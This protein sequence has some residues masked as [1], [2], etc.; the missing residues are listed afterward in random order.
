[1]PFPKGISLK[2]SEIAHRDFEP[3]YNGIADQQ[4]NHYTTPLMFFL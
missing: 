1:M 2:V 4:F 3:V